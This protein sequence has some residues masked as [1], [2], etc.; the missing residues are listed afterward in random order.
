MHS[1]VSDQSE[2]HRRGWTGRA[3]R[4]SGGC[5]CL[6]QEAT[7]APVCTMTVNHESKTTTAS[8]G[9]A[10]MS[11]ASSTGSSASNAK[12]RMRGRT[13]SAHAARPSLHGAPA[14]RCGVRSC[15]P[16]VVRVRALPWNASSSRVERER[17][18]P[19]LGHYPIG[20]VVCAGALVYNGQR[21]RDLL[22]TMWGTGGSGC[23]ACAR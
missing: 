15:G 19:P 3:W 22:T 12:L 7:W 20:V 1:K 23:L 16:C 10:A 6:T 21:F 8:A 4:G 13:M 11:S 14:T 2:L 5:T 17:L 18:V 9:T